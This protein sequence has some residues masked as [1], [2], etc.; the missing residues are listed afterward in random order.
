MND[1]EVEM[2]L[3]KYRKTLNKVAKFE[4]SYKNYEDSFKN[5]TQDLITLGHDI[6]KLDPDDPYL[7]I[8]KSSNNWLNENN[9]HHS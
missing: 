2:S 6:E 8:S 4:Q 3:N 9:S 1:D 7:K 5:N